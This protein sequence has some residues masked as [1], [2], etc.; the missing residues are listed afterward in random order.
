MQAEKIPNQ[1]NRQLEVIALLVGNLMSLKN[2]VVA[3]SSF[4][5][6]A[7]CHGLWDLRVVMVK[8]STLTDKVLEQKSYDFTL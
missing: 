4:E 1:T 2:K 5:A 7:S 8:N 6:K 3:R